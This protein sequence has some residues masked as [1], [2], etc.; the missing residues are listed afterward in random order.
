MN[1]S[2]GATDKHK[3][4]LIAISTTMSNEL[5]L[6]MHHKIDSYLYTTDIIWA[7]CLPQMETVL[8]T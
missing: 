8:P 7:Q 3:Y 6:L 2:V 1:K 4:R 5:E